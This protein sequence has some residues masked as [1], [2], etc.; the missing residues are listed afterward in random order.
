MKENADVSG[1]ETGNKNQLTSGN[2]NM[3][4]WN[5]GVKLP[6]SRAGVGSE[7]IQTQLQI[8]CRWVSRAADLFF[9]GC[10]QTLNISWSHTQT[11]TL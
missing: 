5:D 7:P 8:S 3:K 6:R 1:K 10:L 11:V 2:R 9:I 4:R